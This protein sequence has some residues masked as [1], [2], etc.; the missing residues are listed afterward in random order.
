MARV[1][2]TTVSADGNTDIS[3]KPARKETPNR[4]TVWVY[5]GGGNDFGS[6][7]VTLQGSP[8]GG[9]TFIDIPDQAGTA[10]TFTADGVTNFELYG[11]ADPVS[12]EVVQI[13]LALAGSTSP[14]IRYIID[15]VR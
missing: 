1:L 4:A 15:D 3:W 2:D 10:I 7:T 13:R 8:D 9:T 5:G 12:S 14:T 11:N 6:G